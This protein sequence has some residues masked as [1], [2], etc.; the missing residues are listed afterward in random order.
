MAKKAVK[1]DGVWT[2]TIERFGYDLFAV[3]RTEEEARKAVIAEYV[4]VY[5]EWNG[6]DPYKDYDFGYGEKRS[7]GEIME[8][9]LYVTFV[10]FGKVEWR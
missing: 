1:P 8:D 9:E 2:A 4:R 10:E 3:G 6:I 7:Y 5:K